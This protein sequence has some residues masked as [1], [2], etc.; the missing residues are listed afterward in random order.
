MHPGSER[1]EGAPVKLGDVAT[2]VDSKNFKRLFAEVWLGM[3]DVEAFCSLC[4][5]LL[6]KGGGPSQAIACW[7][8]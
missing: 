8:A 1:K 3:L 6:S 2:S 7:Q 5:E 4:L